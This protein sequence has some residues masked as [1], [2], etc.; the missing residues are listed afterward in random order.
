[1]TDTDHIK[2]LENQIQVLKRDLEF[3]GW[4]AVKNFEENGKLRKAM[5]SFLNAH[6]KNPVIKAQPGSLLG[7]ECQHCIEF[8]RATNHP[9]QG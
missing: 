6:W 1:M 8:R 9:L 5:D 3:Q 2:S 4:I 7:C